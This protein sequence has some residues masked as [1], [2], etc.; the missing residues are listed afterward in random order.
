MGPTATTEGKRVRTESVRHVK[1]KNIQATKKKQGAAVKF[2]LCPVLSDFDSCR[3]AASC[4]KV[5]SIY[6][7]REQ[8]VQFLCCASRRKRGETEENSLCSWHVMEAPNP[9]TSLSLEQELFVD[10]IRCATLPENHSPIKPN[11]KEII[12]TSSLNRSLFLPSNTAGI[13]LYHLH[14]PFVQ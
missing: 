2:L 3:E 6:R 9:M 13:Y 11:M 12:K 4:A 14:S 10:E 8:V 1:A 7:S 5:H